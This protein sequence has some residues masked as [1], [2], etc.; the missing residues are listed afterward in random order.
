M[1]Y[2][3]WTQKQKSLRQVSH[4][5]KQGTGSKAQAQV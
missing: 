4:Q 3:K 2:T 5:A 1:F